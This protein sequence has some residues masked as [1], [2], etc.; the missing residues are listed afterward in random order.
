LPSVL[1]SPNPAAQTTDKAEPAPS[2]AVD[3]WALGVTMYCLLF[4][5]TPFAG[6]SEW[7]LFRRIRED[8]VDFPESIPVSIA[9]REL[10]EGMM[11]KDVLDRWTI[12]RIALWPWTTEGM[13]AEEREDWV[14]R[15]LGFVAAD[16]AGLE[17][18]VGE[19][20]VKKAVGVMVS[21]FSIPSTE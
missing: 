6:T 15:I 4:G 12:E 16:M 19:E 1:E 11:T 20:E 17:V 8:D 9:C 10:L 2:P 5:R 14:G 7:T 3:N 21:C 13:E 18:E